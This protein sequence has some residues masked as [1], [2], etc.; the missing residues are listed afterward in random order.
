VKERG[1]KATEKRGAGLRIDIQNRL[2]STN[3]LLSALARI[4]SLRGPL[5]LLRVHF[6]PSHDAAHTMLW[7]IV[8]GI[9][10]D[11]DGVRS[12][13]TSSGG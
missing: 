5:S 1:R 4:A 3:L 13:G 8:M 12:L 7:A 2:L 9:R 11:G 6:R 10:G